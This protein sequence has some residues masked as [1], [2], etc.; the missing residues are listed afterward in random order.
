MVMGRE[1]RKGTVGED[2]WVGEVSSN[3]ETLG[4]KD[5]KEETRKQYGC[6]HRTR[7]NA[8]GVKHGDACAIEC[9][10]ECAVHADATR[11]TKQGDECME[12]IV[13]YK[14]RT[15]ERH[16]KG[17]NGWEMPTKVTYLRT[18]RASPKS[19]TSREGTVPL[20]MYV[21]V[22]LL[23][24]LTKVGKGQAESEQEEHE[25]NRWREKASSRA[26]NKIQQRR[27]IQR[28]IQ[29]CNKTR[30]VKAKDRKKYRHKVRA[31]L[32]WMRRKLRTEAMEAN[33]R[34]GRNRAETR[35]EGKVKRK[36]GAGGR[37]EARMVEASNVE[38]ELM[39]DI[40]V[41]QY[42]WGDGS[43][44]LWAVAGALQKLEGKEVP[45]ANDIRLEKEWRAAI[46]DVITTHGIPITDEDLRGLKKGVQYMY[47][48]LTRGGTW[49]GGTEHQALAMFLK[50]NIVIWDRRYIG[51]VG[52]QHRQLY[53]CTPHGGTYLRSVAQAHELLK[54]SEFES[55]HVLYDAA[56]K[57]YEYFA[58]DATREDST[59]GPGLRAQTAETGK[60][61]EIREREN[62]GAV[63]TETPRN[64]TVGEGGTLKGNRTG[65]TSIREGR[66]PQRSE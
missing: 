10:I 4:L 64:M 27:I 11:K 13:E 66:E 32:Q 50:V 58:K 43:C 59:D 20:I 49:G 54:Q 35:N 16:K 9:E 12:S 6:R 22:A 31:S 34:E 42:T 25:R 51:R 47:G 17:K 2:E 21:Y 63:M 5:Q 57:H 48:K 53:V 55:I 56:A 46:Q 14:E 23:S 38:E 7:R 44:W 30:N 60:R 24:W 40:G 36:G 65:R 29:I 19:Y 1:R 61:K 28:R 3:G 37:G 45:T 62:S 39:R 15:T 33:L 41:P 8:R 26:A 18:R 52:E